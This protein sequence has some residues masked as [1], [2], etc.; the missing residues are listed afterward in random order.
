MMASMIGYEGSVWLVAVLLMLVLGLT[1]ALVKATRAG[2]TTPVR[3][4]RQ[5]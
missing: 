3:G 4:R 1:G 5:R 2:D